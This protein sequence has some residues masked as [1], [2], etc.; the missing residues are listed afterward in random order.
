MKAGAVPPPVAP[1]VA[2]LLQIDLVGKSNARSGI[3]KINLRVIYEKAGFDFAVSS[4]F[5][6]RQQRL[7]RHSFHAED[8]HRSDL[9]TV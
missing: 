8:W 1:N 7:C 9:R 2:R 3:K 4:G 5:E 6:R